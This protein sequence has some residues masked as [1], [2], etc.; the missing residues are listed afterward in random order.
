MTARTSADILTDPPPPDADARVV[1]GPEPL[2]FGDLRLP[3]PLGRYL[4]FDLTEEAVLPGA[5]VP[6]SGFLHAAEGYRN[7]AAGR[8]AEATQELERALELDGESA[9]LRLM[10]AQ[11]YRAL[12]QAQSAQEQ[13]GR[14][15]AAGAREGERFPFP[16]AIKPLIY[17]AL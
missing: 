16:S 14:A 5:V 15:R 12:G 4:G 6:P 8:Y 7:F 17:L 11:V 1:Y 10:L 3:A 13:E 2:Q 9:P